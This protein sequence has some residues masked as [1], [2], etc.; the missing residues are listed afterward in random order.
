MHADT[1]VDAS[2]ITV[3][4]TG[5]QVTLTGAVPSY[6][7]RQAAA[8]DAWIVRGVRL[9]ED[10]IAVASPD[11]TAPADAQVL[12]DVMDRLD[13][14][15]DI[16]ATDI[17][18]SV[19]D[20]W[21]TLEGSVATYW[22][23]EVADTVIGAVPGVMGVTDK[24]AVVPTSDVADEVIA[25]DIVA[26]LDRGGIVDVEAVDVEVA[27]GHVTLHGT[28]PS[29]NARAAAVRTARYTAGV[30]DVDDRLVVGTGP[31]PS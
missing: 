5:G 18:A 23:K 27:N 24:L 26:A 6:R 25:D 7:Q 10:L 15:P 8:D 17:G 9:V 22:E 14:D 28:A 21:V 31:L 29:W 13:R 2:Q 16:D 4:V 12:A 30:V 20:G 1:R 19:A 11:R 3:E